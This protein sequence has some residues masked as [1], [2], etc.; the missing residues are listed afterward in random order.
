MSTFTELADYSGRTAAWKAM[1]AGLQQASEASGLEAATELALACVEHTLELLAAVQ[2]IPRDAA[3]DFAPVVGGASPEAVARADAALLLLGDV[4]AVGVAR[5]EAEG[6]LPRGPGPVAG[7]TVYEHAA[8][9]AL[10]DE[11]TLAD[12]GRR[13][14]RG[15]LV[16]GAEV[17]AMSLAS[18]KT[19]MFSISYRCRTCR[20]SSP[21]S[22]SAGR[23]CGPCASAASVAAAVT[24]LLSSTC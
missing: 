8:T 11:P 16:L 14:W 22:R 23:R 3:N 17:S 2:A 12:A 20:C 18:S 5:L 4:C 1:R 7:S 19:L 6:W 10:S 21:P 9:G 13:G 24:P 15:Q